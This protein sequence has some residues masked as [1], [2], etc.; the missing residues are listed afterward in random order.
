MLYFL[1]DTSSDA[2]PLC[3]LLGTPTEDVWPG[4]TSFPDYKT[5]FPKWVRDETKKLCTNLDQDGL[6][7]LEDMLVYDPAGRI[8]AKQACLH[9][10]FKGGAAAHSGRGYGVTYDTRAISNGNGVGAGSRSA[11]GTSMSGTTVHDGY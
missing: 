9:P 8:S 2:N 4:V 1:L 6:D 10:Y 7:L 11:P 5:S 3:S